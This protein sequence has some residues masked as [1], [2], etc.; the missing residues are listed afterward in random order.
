MTDVGIYSLLLA[1]DKILL[2]RAL[3]RL[4]IDF[5]DF[6]VGTVNFRHMG[7]QVSRFWILYLSGLSAPQ[8]YELSV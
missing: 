7:V 4:P 6:Y 1:R 3:Y 8:N 5:P 2:I